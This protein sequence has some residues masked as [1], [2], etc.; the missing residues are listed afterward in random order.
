MPFAGTD[1]IIIVKWPRHA[2]AHMHGNRKGLH[3]WPAVHAIRSF[4]LA[5]RGPFIHLRASPCDRSAKAYFASFRPVLSFSVRTVVRVVSG[6]SLMPPFLSVCVSGRLVAGLSFFPS[7]AGFAVRSVF[8]VFVGA[9]PLGAAVFSLRCV[10]VRCVC[11][12]SGWQVRCRNFQQPLLQVE[13]TIVRFGPG[14]SEEHAMPRHPCIVVLWGQRVIVVP[15][16]GNGVIAPRNMHDL[17]GWGTLGGA[18]D[19]NHLAC[20][21]GIAASCKSPAW[22]LLRGIQASGRHGNGTNAVRGLVP[23]S[24]TR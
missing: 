15:A 6:A 9:P 17:P 13:Q 23:L 4:R 24:M 18:P 7:E 10:M 16:A 19:R 11:Q 20:P 2:H 22:T 8:V 5:R 3:R 1:I 14:S 21:S 12:V